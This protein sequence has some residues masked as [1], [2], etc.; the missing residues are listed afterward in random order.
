MNK[1]NLYEIA[2]IGG[3]ISSS[4]FASNYI[5]NDTKGR[6]A[7]IENGRN[8]G[9]RS[10]TRNSIS[11]KGWRLNHG[12]PNFNIC[13][14]SNNKLLKA[15]IQ[16]LLDKNI[17]QHDNSDL[18]ELNTNTKFDSKI[19]Y[20]FYDGENY[21]PT[22]SMS[23]LS[24]EIIS[25][26]NLRNQIDYFF[27]TLIYKLEFKNNNWI[28]TSNNGYKFKSK[29]LVCTSNLLLHKRSL[30]ILK[31]DQIPLRN[32]IAKNKE[33]SIDAI[34]HILNKQNYIQRL[35][36]LIYTNSKYSYKDNY[37]KKYRYFIL[38]NLLE[39][40]FG[41]ERVIF[42]RQEN[43]K[44]GIVVHTRNVELINDFFQSNNIERFKRYLLLKFNELFDKNPL[45][46]KLIDFQDISVM[47]W[48]A[49]QPSGVAI[50]EYLQV[51]EKYNIGFCGD[52][53]SFEGFGRTEGAILSALELNIKI[54][55]MY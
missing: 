39:E 21:I 27:E 12:A 53:F 29:F 25:L 22:S 48:R 19:N 31:I 54:N 1:D 33:E 9:G 51:C 5:K 7:I 52:W 20:E 28:L 4:V 38:S 45:I 46:N 41:F 3:G 8:L 24:E 15:F 11:N 10:S 43:N 2:I 14:S 47:N 55:S 13:N 26:N 32:A 42:Q 18:V 36:F 17:I 34:L 49:S 50:P 44:L 37:K 35:T 6:I 40:K 16:E 23:E 30:Q